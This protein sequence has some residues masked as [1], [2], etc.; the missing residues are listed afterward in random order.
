MPRA[1]RASEW[2]LGEAQPPGR[3]R[4]GLFRILL[5]QGVRRRRPLW[6]ISALLCITLPLVFQLP[7]QGAS[8]PPVQATEK[9]FEIENPD[10]AAIKLQIRDTKGAPQ[11]LFVCRTGEQTAVPQVVY[12]NDLDCRL[13]PASQGEI[14][15]NLLVEN[16]HE[17]A[18][19]SRGHMT[20]PDL[21]GECGKYPEYG[22]LRH[23][24]LR[25]LELTL[26]FFDVKFTATHSSLDGPP[27]ARLA[28]YKLRL[29]V[30]PD[31]TSKRN[32]SERSG[33]LD[34]L[35]EGQTP[36]R[37]CGDVRKGIKR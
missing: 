4:K 2:S 17:K 36:T 21:Y 23:F 33:Y 8:W 16:P 18:W 10:Q 7:A 14:E 5:G 32:I 28:S 26:E 31:P 12:A 11:Y 13:I 19:F 20:A 24:R 22:Q 37:S 15:E 9:V 29:A 34:P 35:R 1:K 30:R 25:G 6:G 27:S 3:H